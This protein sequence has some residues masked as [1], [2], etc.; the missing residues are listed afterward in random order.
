VIKG[1]APRQL[2]GTLCPNPVLVGGERLDAVLGNGFALITT[3]RPGP[4]EWALLERHGAVVHI[5]ERGSELARWLRRGNATAA[6]V[7]PDRAVMCAGR[8]LSALCAATP[9]FH[10]A[11]LTTGKAPSK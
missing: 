8:N 3:R 2:A 5:A 7:R 9:P 6:V 10:R 4:F 1:R 11:P